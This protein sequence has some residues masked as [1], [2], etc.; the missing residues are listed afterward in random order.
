MELDRRA[1]GR[2]RT[3][4]ALRAEARSDRTSAVLSANGK[5]RF[6]YEV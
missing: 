6:E 4:C 3:A 2:R 1:G 5:D